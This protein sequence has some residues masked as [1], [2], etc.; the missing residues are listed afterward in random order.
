MRRKAQ[1]SRISGPL[2]NKEADCGRHRLGIDV[3][4]IAAVQFYKL[5]ALALKNELNQRAD[6]PATRV[7]SSLVIVA[8]PKPM[9]PLMSVVTT[10]PI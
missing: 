4:A 8:K 6:R 7:K 10:A 2:R 3:L 5:K 9:T 1:S